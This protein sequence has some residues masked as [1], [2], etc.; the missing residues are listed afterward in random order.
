MHAESSESSLLGRYVSPE[1]RNRS[2]PAPYVSEGEH[3]SVIP[4]RLSISM[5]TEIMKISQPKRE[6]RRAQY[7]VVQHL[8]QIN[9]LLRAYEHLNVKN[10][11]PYWLSHI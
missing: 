11:G 7:S 1:E 3:L 9:D 10:T 5:N 8:K 6:I 2:M 4:C